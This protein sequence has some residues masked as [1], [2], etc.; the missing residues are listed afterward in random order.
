M[1]RLGLCL[2]LSS[3]V[4]LASD[5]ASTLANMDR[6]EAQF[7]GMTA[8]VRM[9]TYTS[10]VDNEDIREGDMVA[11]RRT[12]KG[13]ASKDVEMKIHFDTPRERDLLVSGM[14]LEIYNPKIG[15]VEE[16][17]LTNSREK[18]DQALMSG[19]GVAGSY[20]AA[21][22]DIK[23]AGEEAVEGH[24]AVKLEMVP[25]DAE[26]LRSVPKVEM[27]IS[28]QIWQ[29]VQQKLY[30]SG[31]GDYQLYR[32]TDVVINPAMKDSAFRLKL[33]SKVKRITPGR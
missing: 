30:Q 11:R 33:P 3:I 2:A 20:L 27:W 29:P 24:P 19:F 1:L 13:A 15:I 7:Q 22:Y 4:L 10:L 21:T 31:D 17:D 14:K 16:Y 6:A 12:A 25:K 18:V 28:T 23:L 26:M 8:R 9:V 32:Y 5:L